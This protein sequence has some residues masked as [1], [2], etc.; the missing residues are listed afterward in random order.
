MYLF[1]SKIPKEKLLEAFPIVMRLLQADNNVVHSYA[2]I[3]IEKFLALKIERQPLFVAADVSQHL[4]QLLQLLFSSLGK[5]DST[6]N[7]YLIRA[8]MRVVAFV[9]PQI[10]PVAGGC[11]DWYVLLLCMIYMCQAWSSQLH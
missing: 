9:G 1:R 10:I 6:E 11:L 8:V 4:N 3:V 7:E 2:S 5:P